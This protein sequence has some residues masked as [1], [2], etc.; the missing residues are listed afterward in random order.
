MPKETQVKFWF[1]QHIVDL[2]ASRHL[3]YTP[4]FFLLLLFLF[5]VFFFFLFQLFWKM[6]QHCFAVKLQ[7]YPVGYIVS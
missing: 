4:I 1:P 6:L 7:K 2:R 5:F 3:D